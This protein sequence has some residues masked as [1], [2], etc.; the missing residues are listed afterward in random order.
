MQTVSFEDARF[1]VTICQPRENWP[2]GQVPLAG[3]FTNC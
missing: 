2:K 3:L 1:V